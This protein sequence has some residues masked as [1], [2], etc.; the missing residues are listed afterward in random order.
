MKVFVLSIRKILAIGVISTVILVLLTVAYSYSRVGPFKAAVTPILTLTGGNVNDIPD[1]AIAGAEWYLL[2]ATACFTALGSSI[3]SFISQLSAAVPASILPSITSI[4]AAIFPNTLFYY[5]FAFLAGLVPGFI[6][7]RKNQDFIN[8]IAGAIIPAAAVTGVMYAATTIMKQ[9]LPPEFSL[10]QITLLGP[11]DY[12]LIF[13]V[14]LA[15]VAI[16]AC[17]PALAY[18]LTAKK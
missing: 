10:L 14:T 12:A 11:S 17:V 9:N 5:V 3:T 16:G 1:F 7:F 4:T 6:V 13:I 18:K 8:A 2:V 15:A